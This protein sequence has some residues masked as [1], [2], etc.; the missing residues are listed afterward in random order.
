MNFILDQRPWEM[1]LAELA[2]NETLSALKIL[3]LLEEADE[4]ETE[5]FLDALAQKH[6]TIDVASLPKIAGG[7]DIFQIVEGPY[8]FL[9]V[10]DQPLY[11]TLL[12][13]VI[14]FSLTYFISK[15]IWKLN[16]KYSI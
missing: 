8:P 10:E 9:M 1:A 12:W 7:E 6:I 15:M 4:E 14:V 16:I 5:E 3:A 11:M 13:I 2:E